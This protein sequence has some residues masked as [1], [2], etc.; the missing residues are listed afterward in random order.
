MCIV[1]WKSTLTLGV[2]KQNDDKPSL[3]TLISSVYSWINT[4]KT[5]AIWPK[6][7]DN[8]I[9]FHFSAPVIDLTGNELPRCFHE[10]PLYL[11]S[12][13]H[14]RVSAQNKASSPSADRQKYRWRGWGISMQLYKW[15]DLSVYYETGSALFK[16]T[17]KRRELLPL[18]QGQGHVSVFFLKLIWL[19]NNTKDNSRPKLQALPR[20]H[21]ELRF[22]N[23]KWIANTIHELCS[24]HG[25]IN[26]KNR[27]LLS[28]P[29][30]CV[31]G[32]EMHDGSCTPSCLTERRAKR[33]QDIGSA[34]HSEA[35]YECNATIT[36][37]QA[38]RQTAPTEDKKKWSVKP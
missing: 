13:L 3:N 1:F 32:I 6:L 27:P 5:L 28:A 29:E 15:E 11:L 23:D 19:Q 21:P 14:Q 25:D 20:A 37:P 30:N 4:E 33:K 7:A 9:P 35:Y 36:R 8:P 22:A 10:R 12:P 38:H 16:K 26:Q 24:C 2:R 31:C 34:S 17:K 18:R